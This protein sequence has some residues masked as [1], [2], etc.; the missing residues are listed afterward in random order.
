[1]PM[2]SRELLSPSVRPHLDVGLL[3]LRVFTGTAFAVA[4][5]YGK[6]SDLAKF[7][8]S[9]ARHGFPMPAVFATAAALSEFLGGLLLAIGLLTRPAAAALLFT[10]GVAGFFIH[11][12]DPFKKKE[13]AFAYATVA[14]AILAAGP[15]RYSVDHWLFHRRT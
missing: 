14:F 13:L 15:G 6:V 9:V 10:M 4:H 11:A 1:M 8:A 3:L 7:T 2:R 5:G 12:D